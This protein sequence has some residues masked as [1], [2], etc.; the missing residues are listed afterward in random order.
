MCL[1]TFRSFRLI[2]FCILEKGGGEG[3]EKEVWSNGLHPSD[4]ALDGEEKRVAKVA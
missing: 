2:S 1:L 3:R 4:A